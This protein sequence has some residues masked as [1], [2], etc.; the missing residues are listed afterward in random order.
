MDNHMLIRQIK[1][2]RDLAPFVSGAIKTGKR[3][4]II[5]HLTKDC[6]SAMPDSEF[7]QVKKILL[8]PYM[9]SVLIIDCDFSMSLYEKMYV[10]DLCFISQEGA[11]W[12]DPEQTNG[13]RFLQLLFAPK[14]SLGKEARIIYSK[15]LIKFGFANALLRNESFYED[16]ELQ[17]LNLTLDR[18]R[19]QLYG[20]KSCMNAYK[21]CC[22]LGESLTTDP[23]TGH[24]CQLALK[25]TEE[26]KK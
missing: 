4:V 5:L 22:L 16:L 6:L 9:I 13:L 8:D 2:V 12:F 23:E 18:T 15:E 3:N 26:D 19:E 14:S 7:Q 25:K 11:L 10:F 21:N 1:T 24:F 20:I 17:I